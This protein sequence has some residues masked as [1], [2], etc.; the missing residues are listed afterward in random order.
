MLTEQEKE[1]AYYIAG[2]IVAGFEFGF[3]SQDENQEEWRR[4]TTARSKHWVALRRR[5][6]YRSEMYDQWIKPNNFK[7]D[8]ENDGIVIDHRA[9]HRRRYSELL[10][11]LCIAGLTAQR[12][13]LPECG[14]RS[15]PKHDPNTDD[16]EIGEV[17]PTEG[18]MQ[19][20][21]TASCLLWRWCGIESSEEED[22]YH[23][24]LAARVHTKS[25]TPVWRKSVRAVAE[26][27]LKQEDL[28]LEDAKMAIWRVQGMF[29]LAPDEAAFELDIA[30]YHAKQV[31]KYEAMAAE[32]SEI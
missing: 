17:S 25:N 3:Y 18:P 30:A 8:I 4:V 20:L 23:N 11:Q 12:E 13:N 24:L 27:I 22:A 2:T 29:D 32:L 7:S 5:F 15:L 16:E 10:G 6:P 28:T 21:V 9:L 31:T 26:A 19:D 1:L 14:K